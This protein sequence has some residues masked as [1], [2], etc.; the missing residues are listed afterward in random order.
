[1]FQPQPQWQIK[2]SEPVPPWYLETI[3]KY[4]SVA[5]GQYLAQLLWQREITELENLPGFL[6]SDYYQPTSPFAF[7]Q[8]MK[9]AT[10][11]IIQARNQ[12]KKVAIWGDFD[13]DGVT[14][15]S[16][17]LEGLANFFQPQIELCYYIPN[18]LKES[19]GLNFLGIE[20]NICH[21]LRKYIF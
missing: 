5:D 15:T 1:M 2:Q 17:L 11:I 12:S 13:A 4:T 16:V 18:R 3:K 10:E 6:N 7:G 8:E 21:L 19:H 9:W 14:A 20:L